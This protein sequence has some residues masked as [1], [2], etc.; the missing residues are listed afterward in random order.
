MGAA[1]E[2]A[3]GELVETAADAEA[4]RADGEEVVGLVVS[5]DGMDITVPATFDDL[6]IDAVEAFSEIAAAGAVGDESVGTYRHLTKFL[7][8]LLGARQWAQFKKGRPAKA[9][10]SL[11][12]A[13]MR[14]YGEARSGE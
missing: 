8:E 4:A 13:I 14:A 9:A 6:S 7:S 11:F 1:K 10:G 3:R 2:K 5:Y 12:D